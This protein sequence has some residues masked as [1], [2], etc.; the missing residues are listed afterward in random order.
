MGHKKSLL[1]RY[2]QFSEDV[3]ILNRVLSATEAIPTA[4]RDNLA[5][6]EQALLVN[7]LQMFLLQVFAFEGF[8]TA[9]LH[10]A[11]LTKEKSTLDS[12][13]LLVAPKVQGERSYQRLRAHVQEILKVRDAWVHGQGDPRV[14]RRPSLPGH[15][16]KRFGLVA[17]D[18]RLWI[19]L[20]HKAPGH[21][22]VWK[23]VVQNLEKMAG[24]IWESAQS[25]ISKG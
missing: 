4:Y 18:G 9:C 6:Q 3:R 21:P 1:D 14:L 24:V 15:F 25:R 5:A 12:V 8:V 16:A 20:T 23:F 17:R 22:V 7:D 19:R 2:A 10:A 13:G 11:G